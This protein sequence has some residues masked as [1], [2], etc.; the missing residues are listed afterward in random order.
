MVD[1]GTFFEFRVKSTKDGE[2]GAAEEVARPR[3]CGDLCFLV[4]FIVLWILQI[5]VTV[6]VVKNGKPERLTRGTDMLGNLCGK[7]PLSDA[8]ISLSPGDPEPDLELWTLYD[9]V[10]YPI[11]EGINHTADEALAL[12][13]C[14]RLGSNGKCP[15]PGE[16]VR[17]YSNKVA[18]QEWNVS[19]YSKPQLGRC[20][21][22]NNE[23]LSLEIQQ[24]VKDVADSID[25]NGFWYEGVAEVYN[26]HKVVIVAAVLGVC[27]S[28]VWTFFIRTSV[29]CTAY[30]SLILFGGLLLGA[31][32]VGWK[33]ADDLSSDGDDGQATTLN[34]K[35]SD[36]WRA[37]SV[38]CWVLVLCVVLLGGFLCLRMKKLVAVVREAL[39]VQHQI[40]GLSLVTVWSFLLIMALTVYMIMVAIHIETSE[41]IDDERLFDGELDISYKVVK[42]YS[43]ASYFHVL[44][45]IVWLWTITFLHHLAYLCISFC[46]VFWY[47]SAKGDLKEAPEGIGFR[48]FR[49]AVQYHLGTVAY[50]SFALFPGQILKIIWYFIFIPLG[51]MLPA[52]CGGG[53]R[54]CC[55][56]C[57]QCCI[58]CYQEGLR[59]LRLQAYIMTAMLGNGLC[60][61]GK[62]A[63][64]LLYGKDD[65]SNADECCNIC[66][67]GPR[68]D[69]DECCTGCRSPQCCRP[70]CEEDTTQEGR[71][72]DRH[73]K[74]VE[75]NWLSELTIILAKTL[76]TLANVVFSWFMIDNDWESLAT[77]SVNSTLPLI[78]IAVMTYLIAGIFIDTTGAVVDNI[79][80]C[81]CYDL[82]T[83][84]D[85]GDFFMPTGLKETLLGSLDDLPLPDAV[86]LLDGKP[87]EGVV[88]GKADDFDP[89]RTVYDAETSVAAV[90]DSFGPPGGQQ[91]AGDVRWGAAAGSNPIRV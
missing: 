72:Q 90:A 6:I 28:L 57:C 31:G 25:V 23:G 15:E 39:K 19:Y 33:Y 32:L 27:Y 44:N 45:I 21:P 54:C 43:L 80:I 48:G 8:N 81:F 2:T 17:M 24:K 63:H 64:E 88:L 40:V 89:E 66:S 7:L 35:V 10:W 53:R 55:N 68:E 78:L 42:E 59:Y 49:T 86:P 47:F 9:Y 58:N 4:F 79:V 87:T 75:V 76:I 69:S 51:R 56:V 67:C 18:Y 38:F 83:N 12:G 14:I 85:T 74:V 61:S 71:M 34:V 5:V 1:A 46:A 62:L 82:D 73:E 20:V 52:L 13:T 22:V 70:C 50:G 37:F 30:F 29:R 65:E 26:T 91:P 16:T 41:N 3:R 36:W 77:D 11:R 84:A 60:R